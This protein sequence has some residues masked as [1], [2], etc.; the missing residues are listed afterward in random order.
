MLRLSLSS[1]D[2]IY[3]RKETSC[4]RTHLAVMAHD[5]YE[6]RNVSIL[7]SSKADVDKMIEVLTEMKEG[8]SE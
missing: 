3:F 4:G 1:G 5:F 2:S 8:L 6:G 7:V